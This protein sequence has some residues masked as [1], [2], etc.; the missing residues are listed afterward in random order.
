MNS[1][2]T[3]SLYQGPAAWGTPNASPFCTKLLCFLNAAKLP[4]EICNFDPIKAPKGKMPYI[5]YQ[6]KYLGDS[7]FIIK[8]L[9]QEFHI[10]LDSH[11]TEHQKAIGHACR[12]MLEDGTYFQILWSRWGIDANW[13]VVKKAYFGSMPPIVRTILPEILRRSVKRSAFGQ[14]VARHSF[15]ELE[16]ML[17]EDMSSLSKLMSVSGPYFHG[18]QI[19]EIDCTVYAFLSSLLCAPLPVPFGEKWNSHIPFKNYIQHVESEHFSKMTLAQ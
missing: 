5:R 11:L 2:Q 16:T 10:Q 18:S 8:F 17:D 19:S 9:S 15:A 3:I 14:G 4:Y 12:R 13:A 6:G 7:Q 1:T